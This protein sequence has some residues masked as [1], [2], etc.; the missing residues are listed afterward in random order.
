MSMPPC[1]SEQ[2]SEPGLHSCS[3]DQDSTRL[4]LRL[5]SLGSVSAAIKTW[6]NSLIQPPAWGHIPQQHA[7]VLWKCWRPTC[8]AVRRAAGVVFCTRCDD[9]S[10]PFTALVWLLRSCTCPACTQVLGCLLLVKRI[11]GRLPSNC[12]EQ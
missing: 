8:S 6:G 1:S 12:T 2:L 11:E 4:L 5:Q 7:R 3:G 10:C 9:M